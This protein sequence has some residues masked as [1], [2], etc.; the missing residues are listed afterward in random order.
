MAQIVKKFI[1][2]DA[3]DGTKFKLLNNQ[4]LSARNAADSG[5]VTLFKLN[6]SD[7][8]EFLTIPQVTSTPVADNDVARKK[9]VDDG[10]SGKQNSLGFTP[11]DVANKS[12]NT[13]LG[14]SDTLYP[15]QNAVKSYVD[16]AVSGAGTYNKE[17]LTLNGTDITNQY[18]DLAHIVKANSMDLV[19]NGIVQSEGV[20]YSLST[21]SLVTRVTFLGDLA[22]GGASALVSGDVLKVKYA[23]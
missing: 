17:S 18:K 19:I 6:A 13:S 9:Y 3:V 23:Y 11:E 5:D 22:T 20:D 12:T 14:T 16:T 7:R 8:F 10:L 15:S 1:S 2:S 21:V 4:A